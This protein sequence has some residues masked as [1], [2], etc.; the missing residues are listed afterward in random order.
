MDRWGPKH[1]ELTYMMNKT[2]SFKHFVYLVGLHI[3]YKMIHGPYNIKVGLIE[4]ECSPGTSVDLPH[5]N[6][7]RT[8]RTVG[9]LSLSL[10]VTKGGG[11]L[12]G[13]LPEGLGSTVEGLHFQIVWHV[14]RSASFTGSVVLFTERVVYP[15]FCYLYFGKGLR[16]KEAGRLCRVAGSCPNRGLLRLVTKNHRGDNTISPLPLRHIS[17]I[18][19]CICPTTLSLNTNNW[20]VSVTENTRVLCVVRTEF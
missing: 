8:V 11:G 7:T 5:V 18:Q 16:W 10:L 12:S 13:I 14:S 15:C 20:C 2:H 6:Q 17:V 4:K 1:V 19:H 9:L 3:Y